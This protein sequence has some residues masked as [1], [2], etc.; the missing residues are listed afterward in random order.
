VVRREAILV[1]VVGVSYLTALLAGVVKYRRLTSYHTWLGKLAAVIFAVAVI[2]L[3]SGL[4]R[5]V[6]EVAVP[7]VV[8]SAIE[9]VGITVVLSEWRNNVPSIWHALRRRR[10]TQSVPNS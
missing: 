8:I 5:W 7:L 4:A 1:L 9:E 3:L 2:L 6:F 10:K